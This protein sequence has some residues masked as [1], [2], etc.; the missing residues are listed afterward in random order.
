M[1]N[2]VHLSGFMRVEEVKQVPGLDLVMEIK[3]TDDE[4]KGEYPV[5]LTGKQAELVIERNHKDS[6]KLPIAVI[7][8]RLFNVKDRLVVLGKYIDIVG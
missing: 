1:A 3:I 7:S 6:E 2:T 8:G 4:A 5:F